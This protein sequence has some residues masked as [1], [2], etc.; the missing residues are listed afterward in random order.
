MKIKILPIA[1]LAMLIAAGCS[2]ENDE[3]KQEVVSSITV[4]AAGFGDT[5]GSGAMIN[6]RAAKPYFATSRTADNGY[7]TT[8]V[9]GDKIGVTGVKDG[10]VISDNVPYVYTAGNWIPASGRMPISDAQATYIAYY[11]Y[12]ATMN[13]K[14]TEQEII[15]AF[16]PKTDQSLYADY[17]AS[18]LM[19][20][21]GMISGTVLNIALKHAMSLVIIVPQGID[22]YTPQNLVVMLSSVEHMPYAMLDTGNTTQPDAPGEPDG[23]YRILVKPGTATNIYASYE[24]GGMKAVWNNDGVALALVQAKYYKYTLSMQTDPF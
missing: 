2:N 22:T 10:R 6:P 3:P 14:K 1:A 12:T 24:A 23:T 19:T 4:A 8:M 5:D 11:P 13:G 15:D 7:L 16:A 21:S 18:D 9:E 17:A 20:W